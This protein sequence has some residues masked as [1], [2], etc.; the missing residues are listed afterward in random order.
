M[1][2]K[3]GQKIIVGDMIEYDHIPGGIRQEKV[4]QV[5]ATG[6]CQV[7][8]NTCGFGLHVLSGKDISRVSSAQLLLPQPSSQAADDFPDTLS[9]A[10]PPQEKKKPVTPA[11]NN[12]RCPRCDR[13]NTAGVKCWW[14]DFP[15]PK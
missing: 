6:V 13:R 4:T 2:D 15:I 12:V 14:C 11:I 8:C 1:L 10:S 7:S 5:Y 3:N 9:P